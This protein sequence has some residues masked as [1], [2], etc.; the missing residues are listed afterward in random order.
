MPILSRPNARRSTASLHR[1]AKTGR[2]ESGYRGTGPHVR[3]QQDTRPTV[4]LSAGD[5]NSYSSNEIGIGGRQK[6]DDAR[7]IL[8]LGNT[9]KWYRGIAWLFCLCPTYRQCAL[10]C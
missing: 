10:A 5:V 8:R 2:D 3:T 6:A 9:P 1:Q 7:V 4:V